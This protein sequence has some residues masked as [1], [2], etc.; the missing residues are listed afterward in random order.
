MIK[1]FRRIRRSLLDE[2]SFK[3]YT[4][5]AVGEILL[6]VICILI[7]L[8][9]NNWSEDRKMRRELESNLERYAPILPAVN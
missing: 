1:F 6:V 3:K 2:G 4:A 7:A 9:I 8:Q 5:Y